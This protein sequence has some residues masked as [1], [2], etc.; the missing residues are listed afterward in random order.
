MDIR[1]KVGS[2]YYENGRMRLVHVH[3]PKVSLRNNDGR[4]RKVLYFIVPK[5]SITKC[6]MNYIKTRNVT[7]AY[8]SLSKINNVYLLD[9]IP[10]DFKQLCVQ[11]NLSS[12]KTIS[13][14]S[15]MQSDALTHSLFEIFYENYG[16]LLVVVGSHPSRG[17]PYYKELDIVGQHPYNT[18]LYKIVDNDK[19][20]VQERNYAVHNFWYHTLPRYPF[21]IY[22]YLQVNNRFLQQNE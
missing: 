10:D 1:G 13:L 2:I 6:F 12:V 17:I 15:L 11:K 4:T 8:N 14:F 9:I 3:G 5:N 16:G 21:D 18:E 22:N 7:I 19:L 20:N